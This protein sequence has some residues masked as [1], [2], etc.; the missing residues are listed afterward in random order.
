[1]KKVVIYLWLP[2]VIVAA[3]ILLTASSTAFYFPP[4]LTVLEETVQIWVPEGFV[5]NVIPSLTRLLLGFGIALVVGVGMGIF[6]GAFRRVEHAGRPLI[7]MIRAIP[8][9]ALLPV[10][11]MFLGP[12][13]AMKVS[14][15]AFAA[16]WPIMLNT[17]EGVRSIDPVLRNVTQTFHITPFHRFRYVY[18]PAALPQVFAGGRIALAIAVAVMVAV[19]MFGTPG[20]IGY[21]IRESQQLFQ[22]VAMWS[23]LLVLGVFG[24][25]VNVLYRLVEH[26][27]LRWHTRMNR[28]VKSNGA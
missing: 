20:G 3:A 16:C 25:L 7:D 27:V 28:L 11:M 6:L 23:G 4:A 8:G 12:G 18:L 15:I 9:V 1:M 19:E 13:E 26:R 17:I 10:A 24:Y 22:I 5:K 14:L 2:V 21:F